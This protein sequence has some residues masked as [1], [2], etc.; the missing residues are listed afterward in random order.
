[1]LLRSY[2]DRRV[3]TNSLLRSGRCDSRRGTCEASTASKT[4]NALIHHSCES[5]APCC[6]ARR[7]PSCNLKRAEPRSAAFAF[8]SC[9]APRSVDSSQARDRR[10]CAPESCAELVGTTAEIVVTVPPIGVASAGDASPHR[11]RRGLQNGSREP[12]R[13]FAEVEPRR[14]TGSSFRRPRSCARRRR[15]PCRRRAAHTLLRAA[16]IQLTV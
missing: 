2:Q 13:T 15:A 3:R 1:M 6:V 7:N 11:A 10:R 9:C 5:C 8:P 16:R 14:R 12:V 4:T